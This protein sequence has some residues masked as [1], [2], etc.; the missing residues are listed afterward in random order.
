[1]TPE[2]LKELQSFLRQR[3]VGAAKRAIDVTPD[4]NMTNPASAR[5]IQQAMEKQ[6]GYTFAAVESEYNAYREVY[7]RVFNEDYDPYAEHWKYHAL[8]R[9]L[10]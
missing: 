7:R 10:V 2:Q 1:M 4:P 6:K 3:I 9:K 5:R 8:N